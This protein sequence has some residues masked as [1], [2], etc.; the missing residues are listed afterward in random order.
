VREGGLALHCAQ[1]GCCALSLHVTTD[2]CSLCCSNLMGMAH[3]EGCT[4]F[5]RASRNAYISAHNQ[6][7]AIVVLLV[8]VLACA[9]M[10]WLG[11]TSANS[12]CVAAVVRVQGRAPQADGAQQLLYQQGVSCL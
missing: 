3:E 12:Q 2:L 9:G 8:Y 11:I 6:C 10:V 4:H 5:L 7:V 1:V